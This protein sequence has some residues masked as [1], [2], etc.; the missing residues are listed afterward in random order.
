M[1]LLGRR[2]AHRSPSEAAPSTPDPSAA[3]PRRRGWIRENLE[4]SLP[5]LT[6]A[7]ISLAL[8]LWLH[9]NPVTVGR[10]HLSVWTLVA[11]FGATL[12]GGGV[13]LT[14]I[15]EPGPVSLVDADHLV[16]LRSE[17]E[18]WHPPEAEPESSGTPPWSEEEEAP[19][20]DAEPGVESPPWAETALDAAAVAKAS[21][22][23]LS[24]TPG[25][26]PSPPPPSPISEPAAAG[27]GPAGA[28]SAPGVPP[29]PPP[30][31]PSTTAPP[32]WQEEPLRELES[33]LAEL[34][35]SA[36]PRP[37]PPPP[38]RPR[39]VR[40]EVCAGCGATVASY[41]EQ[42]CIVCDRPLCDS[43]LERSVTEG[44]PS[45]CPH[46]QPPS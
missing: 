13:A 26:E 24:A 8:A 7:G 43:C 40:R 30:T 9:M 28:P 36:S 11:A 42:T 33:V 15:E 4:Y 22:E 44:R 19:G 14:I 29:V 37:T 2:A 5:V 46:C 18:R 25:Y 21:D 20:V 23:L 35:G 45:V 32:A 1:K 39:T 16:V 34:Q 41:S 12:G 31:A 10:G 27:P 17:W 38:T 6:V 3:E